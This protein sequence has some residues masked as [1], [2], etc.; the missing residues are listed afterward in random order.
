[1]HIKLIINF[2][3]GYLN[4]IKVVSYFYFISINNYSKH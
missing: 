2:F 1:M 3:R 4:I